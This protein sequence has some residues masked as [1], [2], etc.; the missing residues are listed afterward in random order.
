LGGTVTV[1]SSGWG[2]TGLG[3]ELQDAA[4]KVVATANA[5]LAANRIES[6]PG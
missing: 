6:G 1:W 2:G 3:A 4:S 5:D